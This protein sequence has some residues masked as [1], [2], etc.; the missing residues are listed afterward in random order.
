MELSKIEQLISTTKRIITHHKEKEELKGEKFNVFS[1]LGMETRENA[2]HSAFICELLNPNGSHLKGNLFLELFLITVKNNI[3][4]NK[5]FDIHT[6]KVIPEH[7][8]GQR[9]DLEK[10]GGRIDIYLCDRNGNSISIENKIYAGDQN[11]Q[12]HRYFNHNKVKNTVYYLTLNG[13][14]PSLESRQSLV[15]NNDFFTISY[16]EH[17][18]KWLGACLKESFDAPILR[19]TI[20]QYLLLIKKLTNTMDDKEKRELSDLILKNH[21]EAALIAANFRTA[22]GKFLSDFRDDVAEKLH[23]ELQ[24]K[25]KIILGNEDVY[26]RW[27]HIWIKINGKE[28][29]KMF[30]GLTSF[31]VDTV[32]ELQLGIFIMNGQ[33]LSE[34]ANIGEKNSNW[35]IAIQKISDYKGFKVKLNDSKTLHKLNTDNV[36]R[37]ELLNHIVKNTKSYLDAYFDSVNNV[38]KLS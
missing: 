38:L 3:L 4:D 31:A 11:V 13:D 8:I 37:N 28:E 19:E 30:F 20:K 17:I 32:D 16:K 23:A 18:Q 15:P 6:S 33:Y 9:N 26:K 2:T 24:D 34:Y 27:A 12:V 21:E 35:W 1:I 22:V 7:F 14:N 29:T 10:E 25:Y 5:P 36:F